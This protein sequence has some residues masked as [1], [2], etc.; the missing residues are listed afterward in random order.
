VPGALNV[1]LVHTSAEGRAGHD[2]YAPCTLG[3]L[4]DLGYDYWALGHVHA[5]EVHARG[6]FV[7]FPGNLQ[8]RSP[9]EPGPK[10]ATVVTV[11]GGRV[12]AIDH[13][14]VDVVRFGRI[15]VEVTYAASLDDIVDLSTMELG[16]SIPDDDRVHVVRLVLTGAPGIGVLL[17]H[18]PERSL[19][20]LRAAATKVAGGRIWIA[21]AWA[22][23][24]EPPTSFR[25]GLRG[26][27]DALLSCPLPAAPA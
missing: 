13:R 18:A 14:A 19:S 17:E 22:E 25:V 21:E 27:A 7:V 16:R 9:R 1:G 11:E 26:C 4:Y 15:T 24:A 3:Q 5:R 10:G 6:A 23:G 8:G 2:P 20:R 12:A